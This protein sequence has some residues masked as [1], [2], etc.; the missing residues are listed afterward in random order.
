MRRAPQK[1]AGSQPASAMAE[2]RTPGAHVAHS[3]G[4][5]GSAPTRRTFGA[6]ATASHVPRVARSGRD[7]GAMTAAE[8]LAELG[9]L[10]ATAHRRLRL[11][12]HKGPGMVAEDEA[13]SD[14]AVDGAGAG[15]A[16]E[17]A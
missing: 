13:V 1:A 16:E 10:L 12:N 11:V 4:R 7:P 3:G 14:P 6:V 15:P 17:V 8:R 5:R 9:A 2:P